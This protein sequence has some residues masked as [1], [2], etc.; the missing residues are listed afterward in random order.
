MIKIDSITKTFD[1]VKSLNDVSLV[2]EKGSIFGL[3][4][5]N[6]SG[7]STLLK[8]MSGVYKP[9]SGG[10][11]YDGVS[12]WENS[13]IKRNVVYLSDNQ[14][15]LPNATAYDMMRLYK[16]VYPTFSVDKFRTYLK[17]FGLDERRKLTT[18]S[19]G[20]QKQ[21]SILLGLACCTEYLFCDETLD[22]LDPVMRQTVRKIIAAEV[23]DRSMCVVFASHNLKEIEDICDH[24]SLLHKGELLFEAGLDDIKLGIHK[25]QLTIPK[26]R[27]DEAS[28]ELDKL[29][30]VKKEKRG[31]LFTIVA[32]GDEEKISEKINALK[33][34]FVEF[35]PLT[36]EEIFIAEMEERGY[37]FD[38]TIIG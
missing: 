28:A 33:P 5:S 29:N 2:I 11:Y 37:E 31:S 38:S 35:I 24:V 9:D 16:S 6:G 15:F 26:E 36:L 10:I 1:V 8:I 34:T 19:K 17:S 20:M 7:K 4:G 18:F 25:I 32:R 14:Y 27:Q 13:E 22:G 23:A 12:V 3:I 30:I 21:V